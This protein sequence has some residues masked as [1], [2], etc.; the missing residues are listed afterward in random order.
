LICA[1]LDDTNDPIIGYWHDTQPYH[2]MP[3]PTS[4]YSSPIDWE[5]DCPLQL[6]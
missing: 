3:S 6:H 5:I 4:A 2:F 1:H